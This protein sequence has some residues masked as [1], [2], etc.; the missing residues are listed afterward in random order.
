MKNKFLLAITDFMPLAQA[1]DTAIAISQ[2][3][4]AMV[5]AVNKQGINACNGVVYE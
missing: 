4:N 2:V 3:G 1:D 5:N